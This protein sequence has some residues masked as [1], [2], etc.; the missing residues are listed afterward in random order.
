MSKLT[1]INPLPRA[2]FRAPAPPANSGLLRILAQGILFLIGL[3]SWIGTPKYGVGEFIFNVS[4]LQAGI[5]LGGMAALAFLMVHYRT[6]VPRFIRDSPATPWLIGGCA[7]ILV[8]AALHLQG[9]SLGQDTVVYLA[10]WAM[11]IFFLALLWALISLGGT[12]PTIFY[13]FIAGAAISALAIIVTR[14]G[15]MLL[16]VGLSGEGRASGFTAHPNQYGIIASGTAPFL[17]YFLQSRRRWQQVLGLLA[18]ALWGLVLFQALSKT[19][20]ILFPLALILTLLATSLN[21]PR[22]FVRSLLLV[23][24]VCVLLAGLA[25]GGLAVVREVAPR[26]AQTV[27]KAFEDPLNARSVEQREGAWEETIEYL[28]LHPFLGLGP[29]WGETHLMYTHAHNLYVQVY[30][31]AGLAGFIGILCVT[32]A[33][34]LRTGEALRAIIGVGDRL[35]EAG[36]IQVM[37]VIALI[38][39]LL[40]NSM[41]S[42]LAVGTMTVFVVILGIAFVHPQARRPLREGAV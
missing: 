3:L 7:L 29:G 33:V 37:A 31:D 25:V 21:R 22:A 2:R 34:L 35:D 32:L 5:P 18:L 6:R 12:V 24:A 23:S 13:G 19:N 39:S 27:E 9:G 40:G 36:R 14:A 38:F 26:E 30:V 8:G 1:T 41:S 28:K 20:L 16:P 11:P 17:V 4:P 42:S 15:I 10:R